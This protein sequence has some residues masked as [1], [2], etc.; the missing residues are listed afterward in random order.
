[1]PLHTHVPLVSIF[2]RMRYTLAFSFI[3]EAL[4][5]L[6]TT[7]RFCSTPTHSSA[8]RALRRRASRR[9][10]LMFWLRRG[11]EVYT[12]QTSVVVVN[13]TLVYS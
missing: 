9:L 7:R 3:R 6:S 4:T 8:A 10:P 5:H 2:N 1:M 11:V 12:C 13:G